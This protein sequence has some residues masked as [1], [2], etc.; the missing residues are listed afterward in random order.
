MTSVASANL[1]AKMAEC[2]TA[3]N[4]CDSLW[5][6]TGVRVRDDYMTAWSRGTS[7][8]SFARLT[9]GG[10][11]HIVIVSAWIGVHVEDWWADTST[12]NILPGDEVIDP[13]AVPGPD[14]AKD[15]W[16]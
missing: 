5:R 14:W 12:D 10:V 1:A 11:P 2:G 8:P 7:R 3:R 4:A 9:D 13:W 6:A 15:Y 16:K